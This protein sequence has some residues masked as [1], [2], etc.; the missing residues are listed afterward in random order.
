MKDVTLY[1]E[2]ARSAAS[3]VVVVGFSSFRLSSSVFDM[4]HVI[5]AGSSDFE[6]IVDQVSAGFLKKLP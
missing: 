1:K 4:F 3:F 2:D 6:S 5:F